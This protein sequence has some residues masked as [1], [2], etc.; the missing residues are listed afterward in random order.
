MYNITDSDIHPHLSA[1]MQQRGV[2]KEEIETVINEGWEADDTK[3]GVF[4]KVLVFPYNRDWE[5]SRFEE[6]EV[7]VYYKQAKD[8][9]IVLTVKARY[10]ENFPRKGATK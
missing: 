10:G 5:G 2:T 1:R 8:R 7:R 4:G 3:P 9:L 6:K